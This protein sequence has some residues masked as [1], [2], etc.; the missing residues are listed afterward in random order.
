M[1]R[2]YA[3][4]LQTGRP[5]LKTVLFWLCVQLMV[6]C[7]S[8]QAQQPKKLPGDAAIYL[9]LLVAEIN[10]FWPDL[11]PREYLAAKID[12]E[13]NWKMNAHLITAREHGCGFGQFTIAKNADGSVRF[14]AL[15]ETKRLDKSLAAWNWRECTNATYQLRAVVLKTHSEERPCIATMRGNMNAKACGAA[16]YNGGAGS[17][18]KRIRFCRAVPGC[19]ADVWTDNLEKQCPQSQVKVKG[20]GETFCEINSKYPGR[21]FARMSKFTGYMYTPP[22][23]IET[24]PLVRDV[25]PVK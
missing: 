4:H 18:N 6:W 11:Y 21:V 15:E 13:S 25:L 17:I 24:N 8:A 10:T 20:Y 14:D 19:E 22:K 9:P 23:T 16:K 5:V 12:Q 7:P 1:A 2:P 3:D